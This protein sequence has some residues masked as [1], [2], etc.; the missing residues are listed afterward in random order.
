MPQ[1]TVNPWWTVRCGPFVNLC[2]A[3]CKQGTMAVPQLGFP[4]FAAQSKTDILPERR[5]GSPRSFAL[6][7]WAEKCCSARS[8]QY[9]ATRPLHAIANVMSFC[10]TQRLDAPSPNQCA[11]ELSWCCCAICGFNNV[12]KERTCRE[13][14]SRLKQS[15]DPN[16]QK[17][18]AIWVPRSSTPAKSID[19][20]S[21]RCSELCRLTWCI[22]KR[23]RRVESSNIL[24]LFGMC[25]KKVH[26]CPLDMFF[27]NSLNMPLNNSGNG[28]YWIRSHMSKM[29]QAEIHET[30]DTRKDRIK[31]NKS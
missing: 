24:I 23:K 19:S 14:W 10:P 6:H 11:P 18:L 20:S 28:W 31:L 26:W 2:L 4:G 13:I 27:K 7:C 9:D 15:A 25:W 29:H 1:L 22:S 12:T 30:R 21:S 8:F 5:R 17:S 3:R 16:C